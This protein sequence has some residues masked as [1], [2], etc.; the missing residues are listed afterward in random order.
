MF[1]Y[2]M[3][4]LLGESNRRHYCSDVIR[5]ST[6]HLLGWFSQGLLGS[7]KTRDDTHSSS[8]GSRVFAMIC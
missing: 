7:G 3:T 1:S 5:E 4:M 2:I 8:Q 6:F